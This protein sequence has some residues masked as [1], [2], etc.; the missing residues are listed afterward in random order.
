MP[1]HEFLVP[2]KRQG[3]PGDVKFATSGGKA[4]AYRGSTSRAWM[5]H[6]ATIASASGLPTGISGP[7]CLDLSV[8]L[9]LPKRTNFCAGEPHAKRPDSSNTLKLIEDALSNHFDDGRIA[10]HTLRKEYWS[11][12]EILVRITWGNEFLMRWRSF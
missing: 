9:S 4:R 10:L 1:V 11:N 5:A 8:R 7:I 3:H 2:G 6:V 12:D